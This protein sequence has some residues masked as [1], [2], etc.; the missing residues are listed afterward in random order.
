M[1]PSQILSH[2]ALHL[3]AILPETR[4]LLSTTA[5]PFWEVHQGVFDPA[6]QG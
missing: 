5:L 6:G 3:A 1:L 4:P 2:D